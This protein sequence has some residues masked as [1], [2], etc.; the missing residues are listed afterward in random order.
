MQS[1]P[2]TLAAI[3]KAEQDQWAI[4]DALLAECGPP[5]EPSVNDGSGLQEV[6]KYLFDQGYSYSQSSLS[7][8]RSVAFGFAA[9]K[10]RNVAWGTHRA[11][12]TS[13]FL[14]AVIAGA[15]KGTRITAE[16]V[17]RIRQLQVDNERRER[18]DAAE[19]ARA[20][21]ERAEE[22]EAQAKARAR[23]AKEEREKQAA[24]AKLAKA[25]AETQRAKEREQETKTAPKKK[26][27]PPAK[28]EVPL[29]AIQSQFIADAAQS[30]KLARLSAKR[31]KESTD[32]LNAKGVAALTEAALEA[33]NAW[34]DAARIVRSEIVNQS[35]HLSVVGE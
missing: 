32:Q 4:G 12:G 7:E 34:T 26:P 16:Y 28:E 15:P 35:G 9:A 31:I 27:E 20:E 29:L 18:E 2:L 33:A 17:K 11:A 6:A 8:Y 22:K 3:K 30:V 24:E 13:Q 5:S 23:E 10:R 25:K 14:D 19:K 21:R 1:F